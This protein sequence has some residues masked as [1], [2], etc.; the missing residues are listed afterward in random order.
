MEEEDDGNEID[1][2]VTSA[3]Q[4]SYDENDNF[5][6]LNRAGG[7]AAI[8]TRDIHFGGDQVDGLMVSSISLGTCSLVPVAIFVCFV[9]ELLMPLFIFSVFLFIRKSR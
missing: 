3:P 7:D 8:S 6:Q 9:P 1:D 5:P 4:T 2:V